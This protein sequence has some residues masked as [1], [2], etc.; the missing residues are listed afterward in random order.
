MCLSV[1]LSVAALGTLVFLGVHLLWLFK[2]FKKRKSDEIFYD[3]K[4]MLTI[5]WVAP[6]C[7]DTAEPTYLCRG[8]LANE[9]TYRGDKR[10][11]E[12][13]VLGIEVP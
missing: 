12:K 5:T 8:T 3:A 7:R 11:H 2:L 1:L 9:H 13:K 6:E 4:W 10:V